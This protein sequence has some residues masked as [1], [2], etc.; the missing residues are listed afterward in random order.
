MAA[1]SAGTLLGGPVGGMAAGYA[2]NHANARYWGESNTSADIA[3]LAGTGAAVTSGL[4]TPG[5]SGINNAAELYSAKGGNSLAGIAV[6]QGS[7]ILEQNFNPED[8]PHEAVTA[9]APTAAEPKKEDARG[10]REKVK[11]GAS[12]AGNKAWD[13]SAQGIKLGKDWTADLGNEVAEPYTLESKAGDQFD[14]IKGLFGF[15]KKKK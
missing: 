8:R 1:A 14:R 6:G 13:L 9:P 15:G 11:D 5:L 4:I 12:Y 7:N 10:W 2:A 3:A